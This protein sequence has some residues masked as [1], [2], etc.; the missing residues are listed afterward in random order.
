MKK[1]KKFIIDTYTAYFIASRMLGFFLLLPFLALYYAWDIIINKFIFVELDDDHTDHCV[2]GLNVWPG[3]GTCSTCTPKPLRQY[4]PKVTWDDSAK[5]ID[6]M[7][8][9]TCRTGNINPEKC[10]ACVDD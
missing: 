6:E 2:H 10:G 7:P 9:C 4:D 3:G 1:I 8:A 5:L